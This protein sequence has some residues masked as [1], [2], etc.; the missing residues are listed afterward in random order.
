MGF[1]Y[2]LVGYILAF[3]FTLGNVYFFQDIIGALVMLVGLSKLA[4]HQKNFLRAMWCD[5]VYLMI[6]TARALL[7]MFKIMQAEG[8]LAVV[9]SVLIPLASLVMQFF[10]FAGIFYLAKE[11][12][13]EKESQRAKGSLMRILSYYILHII[14]VLITPFLGNTVGNITGLLVVVFGIVMLLMNVS[15]IFSC[16][17]GMCLKG[18]ENGART[19][20]KY[21]W[22]NRFNEKT[23][24]MF[25][26]AFLR[27]PRP[28]KEKESVS[29]QESEPGYLRVKRKKKGKH[30]K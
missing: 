15:L 11:V 14:A 29:K 4:V 26:G 8:V 2:L 10:L 18:E 23:D 22:V 13:M 3:I 28:K 16:Y 27:Q 12:E 24:K 30:K 9:F 19:Q 25:D 5:I 6:S 1:G 17:C 21:E 7:M 20:S